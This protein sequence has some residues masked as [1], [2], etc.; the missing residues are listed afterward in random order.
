VKSKDHEKDKDK[1][2]Q[3]DIIV[4]E[5][6]QY[7]QKC[8]SNLA[9]EKRTFLVLI[10]AV[11]L[12]LKP[13][14]FW[15]KKKIQRQNYSGILQRYHFNGIFGKLQYWNWNFTCILLYGKYTQIKCFNLHVSY[16]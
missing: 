11:T 16:Y 15:L 8:N 4:K 1:D 7:I 2:V 14:H 10:E 5:R 9:L 13:Y 3:E 12:H 6:M